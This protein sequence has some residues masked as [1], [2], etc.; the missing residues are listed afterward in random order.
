M[1]MSD[2]WF[3]GLAQETEEKNPP[4]GRVGCTRRLTRHDWNGGNNNLAEEMLGYVHDRKTIAAVTRTSST[5]ISNSHRVPVL[6]LLS[7]AVKYPPVYSYFG[8]CRHFY[9]TKAL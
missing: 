7:C 5:L 6:R 8:N 9:F 2:S 3:S 4:L 1:I